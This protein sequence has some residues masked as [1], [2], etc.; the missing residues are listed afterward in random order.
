[1]RFYLTILL[2][3]IL[4]FTGVSQ[5]TKDVGFIKDMSYVEFAPR[6]KC[7]SPP[8]TSIESRACLNIELRIVDSL[9]LSKFNQFLKK[10]NNDSLK[11]VFKVHQV[12]WEKERKS[13]SI[14]K[15]NGFEGNYEAIMFMYSM[16]EQ[17][18]LRIKAIN[19]IIEEPY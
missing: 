18:K 17:T 10:V 16:L 8:E 4:H 14:H 2:L 1:M 11:A 9:M 12:N 6:V 13:I 3:F 19:A 7:D 5:N 15:S